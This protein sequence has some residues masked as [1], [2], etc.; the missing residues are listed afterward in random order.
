MKTDHS[1]KKQTEQ[2]NFAIKDNIMDEIF[3]LINNHKIT[4]EQHHL[5]YIENEFK[6]NY[7]DKRINCDSLLLE[8]DLIFKG[9][10]DKPINYKHDFITNG[11]K[12][13]VKEIDKW[14]N[15]NDGKLDWMKQCMRSG[16]VTH[17]LTYRAR[18]RDKSR[19]YVCGDKVTIEAIEIREAKEY[20]S[21]ANRSQFSGHYI[22]PL[23]Y[24]HSDEN[25]V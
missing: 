20:L 6:K 2:L 18:G 25:V 22:T 19:L 11:L 10:V 14:H 3:N 23:P 24:L 7:A 4:V 8:Y 16:D 1:L 17:Y 13:D 9:L 5:D 15:I 21:R 12:V